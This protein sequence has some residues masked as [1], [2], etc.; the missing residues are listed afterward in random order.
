MKLFDNKI[1]D[2]DYGDDEDEMLSQSPVFQQQQHQSNTIDGIDRFVFFLI[3]IYIYLYFCLTINI[4]KMML[5]NFKE[6]LY[7]NQIF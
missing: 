6:Y 5:S 4:Q 2:Y 7:D 1:L 3:Y